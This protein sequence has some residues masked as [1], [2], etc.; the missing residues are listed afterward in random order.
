MKKQYY[1]NKDCH[2]IIQPLTIIKCNKHNKPSKQ[3]TLT[4]RYTISHLQ[5]L[6]SHTP[7]FPRWEPNISTK[8]SHLIVTTH[9]KI[10]QLSNF[11]VTLS[12]LQLYHNKQ[13]S[14]CGSGIS[15]DPLRRCVS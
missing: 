5:F 12:I 9:Y 8:I 7:I 15:C 14:D 13:A 2:Y 1:S 4:P 3:N 10:N 6:V 11:S